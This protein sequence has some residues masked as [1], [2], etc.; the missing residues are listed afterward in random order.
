M[1]SLKALPILLISVL[2][3]HA[4][5]ND[6]NIVAEAEALAIDAKFYAESYGVPYDEAVRRLILMHGANTTISNI[7]KYKT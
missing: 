6:A 5:A 7:A 4:F 3:V 1:N 2:S